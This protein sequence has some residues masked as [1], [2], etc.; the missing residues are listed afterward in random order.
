MLH[1]IRRD[2]AAYT[3]EVDGPFSLFEQV[4]KYGLSFALALPALA[5]C[6]KHRIEA[7]VLWG[8]DRR[9]LRF[10]IEG[11]MAAPDDVP[12]RLPD[13]AEALRSRW[14]ERKSKWSVAVN[15]TIIDLPGVGLCVPDLVF[16]RGRSKTRV[17]VEVLGYWSRDAVWKRVELAEAGLPEPVLF[18]A[19][20]RLRV[21]EAVLDDD[22]G[23]A[24]L[25]YKGVIP[26]ARVEEKLEALASKRSPKRAR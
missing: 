3:V 9:P 4:T 22:A 14:L 23:A 6:G 24:L 10:V 12:A 17:H 26:L 7:R 11:E 1:T 15:E 13:D 21:S 18:C 8:A 25:T 19:S 16:T 5:S 2:G 20:T